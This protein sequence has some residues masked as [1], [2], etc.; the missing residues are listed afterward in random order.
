M[1]SLNGIMVG[2][3]D[4][5]H[6]DGILSRA[7]AAKVLLVGADRRIPPPPASPTFEDVS[8]D[9]WY[10]ASVEA[11]AALGITGGCS[12]SPRR[13]C[14]DAPVERQHMAAFATRA[15]G[16]EVD[17]ASA[18]PHFSDVRST[19]A[20]FPYVQKM[21]DLSAMVGC[22]STEF[23]PAQPITRAD[24]ALVVDRLRRML[25]LEPRPPFR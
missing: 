6:P 20:F 13:Y 14:P 7:Q 24:T 17:D 9:A 3:R 10:Y 1:M 23:C 19:N 25:Q 5:F 12:V 15:F 22:S 18:E 11:F 8:S 16:F 4:S 2:E 21:R